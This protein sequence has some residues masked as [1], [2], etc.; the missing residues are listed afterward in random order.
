[1]IVVLKLNNF[2]KRILDFYNDINIKDITPSMHQ[3]FINHLIEKGYSKSTLSKTHNLLKR[4]LERA[5]YD[6]LIYFNPC[7]GITL[8]HKDLKLRIKQNT[9]LKIKLSLFSNG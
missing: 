8:N 2:Q 3:S 6:R 1:M 9:Y 4:S 5:K 7:E